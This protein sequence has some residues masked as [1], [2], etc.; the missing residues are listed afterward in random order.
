MDFI[1]FGEKVCGHSHKKRT[2]SGCQDRFKTRS[3]DNALIIAVA[4]GHGSDK[5]KYSGDG[6][7]YAVVVFC[8]YFDEYCDEY[9]E[10]PN[11]LE[12]ILR[13]IKDDKLPKEIIKK[14]QERVK[15]RHDKKGNRG[16]FEVSL[17]G[18]TLLGLLITDSFYFA[19][20]L[21]DGDILSIAKDGTTSHVTQTKKILGTETYSMSSK[22][23]WKDMIV[24]IR[25]VATKDEFPILFMLSTDGLANSFINEDE[26]LKNGSDYLSLLREH[27][28]EK[29]EENLERWLSETTNSGS[30]DDISLVLAYDKVN[31]QAVS[32]DY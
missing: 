6:A 25:H 20:Q 7:Q 17:Y 19:L 24:E 32:K 31:I 14:W 12:K 9:K 15:A 29:I 11:D 3:L 4:D 18:T 23:S 28:E 13:S 2:I 5:C 30:G 27:G 8:E 21:G 22:E 1:A 26:F 16:E 10:N